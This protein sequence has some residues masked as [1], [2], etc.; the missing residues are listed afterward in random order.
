M[1]SKSTTWF[2]G[3]TAYVNFIWARRLDRRFAVL[4]VNFATLAILF[5]FI[6]GIALLIKY[7]DPVFHAWVQSP[8]RGNS[9]FFQVITRLG[10][11]HWVLI[12]TGIALIIFSFI[13]A[14]RFK[15]Q[16]QLVWHRVL[17]NLWF[18]FSAIAYSGIMTVLLK[19]LFGRARPQFT[20]DN[21][22]WLYKPFEFDY[23]FASFPSG[24]AT[25]GAAIAMTLMLLFARWRWFFALAGLLI[26]ISRPVL[27]VHFP[28]DVAAGV[29]FGAG[30]VW[31][32]A[33][34]FAR[35][36][37]LFKFDP[38]GKLQLRGEKS[39]NMRLIGKMSREILGGRK[40]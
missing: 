24:H 4:P 20:P 30:F 37:V 1:I 3:I 35:K 22:V 11:V 12:P 15:G 34:I 17:L 8:D 6:V 2:S 40:A 18:A 9:Q 5:V 31:V 23:Q 21:L 27:G 39:A 14:K 29:L 32:Y 7:A 16:K 10:K 36:R 26:A 38:S 25:T 33:R 13:N 19:N 28:S